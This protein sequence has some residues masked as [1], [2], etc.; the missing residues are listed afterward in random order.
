MDSHPPGRAIDLG[1]GTGTNVLALAQRGWQ[2][3]GVDFVPRAIALA[4]QK[5]KKAN[6]Q[7]DLRV[8]DV[9]RLDGITGPFNLA[10]DIGC[11]HS[12]P[13]KAAYLSQL[14]RVLAPGGHWL[15]YGFFRPSPHHSGPGLAE[16]DLS[17]IH[18]SGLTLLTRTDGF[19][20]QT[21]PSAWFLYQKSSEIGRPE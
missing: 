11:F 4:K 3:T 9:I 6:L 5:V 10:L 2:V 7:A 19:E 20:R 8:G 15:M 16:A 18:A 17:L 13:D 21:R 12:L 14:E 1:C